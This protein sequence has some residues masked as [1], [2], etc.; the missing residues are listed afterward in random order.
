V[1]LRNLAN[2]FVSVAEQYGRIII[3][4]RHLPNADKTIRP[5]G[6]GGV[7]GGDKYIAQGILFKFAVDTRISDD[8]WM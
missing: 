6:V 1:R 5:V 4:E 2:D 7:A 8:L 3:S